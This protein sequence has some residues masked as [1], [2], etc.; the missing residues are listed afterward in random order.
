MDKEIVD[1]ISGINLN[2]QE[3][4]QTFHETHTPITVWVPNETE[5]K[6]REAQKKTG[7]ASKVL[8]EIV[9]KV[10]EKL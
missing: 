10:V 1:L 8:K 4:K 6:Y 5:A 9:C 7:Q 2:S 3:K